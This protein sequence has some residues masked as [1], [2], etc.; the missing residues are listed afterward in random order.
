M[1][2]FANWLSYLDLGTASP[3]LEDG[4]STSSAPPD[5]ASQIENAAGIPPASDTSVTDSISDLWSTGSDF[6]SNLT[7]SPLLWG[8]L[9]LAVLIVVLLLSKSVEDII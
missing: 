3:G 8:F 7:S 2:F 5:L 9:I 6:F 4:S 1:S